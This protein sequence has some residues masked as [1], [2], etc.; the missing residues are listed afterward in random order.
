MNQKQVIGK[1][2]VAYL[3]DVLD[4]NDLDENGKS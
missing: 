3:S 2:V 1:L 4:E